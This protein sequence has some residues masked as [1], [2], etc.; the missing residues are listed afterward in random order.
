M[1]ME[2]KKRTNSR[3]P[4]LPPDRRAPQVQALFDLASDKAR[5]TRSIM[6]APS[7]AA[8][9]KEA[10]FDMLQALTPLWKKVVRRNAMA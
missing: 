10:I 1:R 7:L 4:R 6:S 2:P 8:A 3:K 5:S 9:A